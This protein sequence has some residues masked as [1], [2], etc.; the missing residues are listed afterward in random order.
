MARKDS[1]IL[2]VDLHEQEIR[3]VE[4][5]LRSNKP[6]L[7][8]IGRAPM[9][10]GAILNGHVQHVGPIA[11]ALRLLLN[12]MGI[13]GSANVVFN[14]LGDSIT[15]RTLSVP[16]VPDKELP[17]IIAGEVSH[18]QLIH[19]PAGAY[20][21]LRLSP[22]TRSSSSETG[23]KRE[24]FLDPEVAEL[25]PAVVTVMAVEEDVLFALGDTAE[26]A[27]LAVEAMEPA[28]Y[29]MFRCLLTNAG[30]TPT[31]FGLMV[32]PAN[33][34]IVFVHK[35]QI[36]GY[37]RID[38]GSR[39]L[40]LQYGT[41][42]ESPAGAAPRPF[43]YDEIRGPTVQH[44]GDL[45]RL[46]VHSLSLEVQRTLNYYQREFPESTSEDNVYIAIDDSRLEGLAKDLTFELGLN[47]DLVQPSLTVVEPGGAPDPNAL[48]PVYAAAFGLAMQGQILSRVPR[49]DL[50]SQQ[51]AGVRKAETQRNFRGSILT[52]VLAISLGVSGFFLYHRQII[53]L[54]KETTET[55]AK[56]AAIKDEMN[57]VVQKRLKKEKQYQELRN[58]GTPVGAV[59]DYISSN[60]KPGTGLQSVSIGNDLTVTIN[61]EAVDEEHLISTN[62]FLQNS[63]LL[64]G[65]QI[66]N[67]HQLQN[68]E[69]D[70]IG[71]QMVGK[72]ISLGRIR[73]PGTKA[74][75][76]ALPGGATAPPSTGPLVP[77][78]PPAG[79][80]G[81]PIATGV[82]APNPK[83]QSLPG[84]PV[85]EVKK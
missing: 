36:V 14:I 48:S 18:Y 23:D 77:G 2:G 25:N 21:F 10:E 56:V 82:P 11:V 47:V 15:L 76:S 43:A 41:T 80:P 81:V 53:D 61:G 78:S 24:T 9:P 74:P 73:L 17:S 1:S 68:Q 65:M 30:P 7:G 42:A 6:F 27:N 33:T 71:F 52:S 50:F 39:L 57:T 54:E 83:G 29:G 5:G 72:T 67:F 40:T 85:S 13:T 49:L 58:E 69:G 64:V 37:R 4:I 38:I 75:V 34:D 46:A 79:S 62:Q 59:M 22:P 16:P 12:S 44:G 51:R 84:A 3:I 28:Q 66:L 32:N 63:P 70:G 55:N 8:K 19:T 20:S 45:N 26:Q 35:G 31:L 60:I